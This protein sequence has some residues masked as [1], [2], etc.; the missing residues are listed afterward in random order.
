MYV[1]YWHPAHDVAHL[2]PKIGECLTGIEPVNEFTGTGDCC[3]GHSA[4]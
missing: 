1:K 2:F 3:S 4:R